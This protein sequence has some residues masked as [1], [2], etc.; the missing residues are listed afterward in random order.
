M[1]CSRATRGKPQLYK[2]LRSPSQRQRRSICKRNPCHRGWK[3]TYRRQ[4][5]SWTWAHLKLFL[6]NLILRENADC[7]LETPIARNQVYGKMTPHI[8][9]G[10]SAFC[11]TTGA[12]QSPSETVFSES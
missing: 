10:N 4:Y 11:P 8:I 5:A 2:T 3:E 6:R 12:K 7:G 9:S 1:I